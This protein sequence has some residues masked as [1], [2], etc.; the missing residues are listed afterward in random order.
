[1]CTLPH[2]CRL[3]V[4]ALQVEDGWVDAKGMFLGAAYVVGPMYKLVG[5]KDLGTIEFPPIETSLLSGDI[6]F[7][8]HSVDIPTD[9]TG[10]HSFLLQNAT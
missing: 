9:L 10:Q 4:V 3:S 2:F 6:A 5:K 1:M 7:R 8:Q